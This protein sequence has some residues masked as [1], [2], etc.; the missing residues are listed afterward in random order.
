MTGSIKAAELFSY[1]LPAERMAQRPVHPYDAARLLI[2]ER[3]MKASTR[4]EKYKYKEGK[5]IRY[6]ILIV[7]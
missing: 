7:R 1:D 5:I 6:S 3:E 4:E 2:I